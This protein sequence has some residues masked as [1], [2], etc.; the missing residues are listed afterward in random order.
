MRRYTLQL[1]ALLLVAI[2]GSVIF[3]RTTS[4]HTA[5][6]APEARASATAAATSPAPTMVARRPAADR[7][8]VSWPGHTGQ[9]LGRYQ[10][11]ASSDLDLAQSGMLTIFLRSVPHEPRPVLSGI[12]AL[13]G[14]S[15]TNVLYLTHFKHRGAKLSTSVNLGIY[16]GPVLG[17]FAVTAR[18]SRMLSASL[19]AP[20][21]APM[22][23][24]FQHVSRNPH[25]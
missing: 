19:L 3:W 17:Q 14:T 22:R 11:S 25:P 12:L 18:D 16:T 15:Q 6:P 1:A 4:S 8:L 10:L 20:G 2:A 13:N 5:L 24:T 21:Q 23:F 7:V 9:Y